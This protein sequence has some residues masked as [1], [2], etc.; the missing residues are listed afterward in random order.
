MGKSR[1]HNIVA[2]TKPPATIHMPQC[3][4]TVFHAYLVYLFAH[5]WSTFAR[6][7]RI[8]GLHLR[9][10]G[11]HVARILLILIRMRFPLYTYMRPLYG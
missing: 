3:N 1:N 6:F 11:L 9:I 4:W 10:N 8:F 2:V 7:P 5:I